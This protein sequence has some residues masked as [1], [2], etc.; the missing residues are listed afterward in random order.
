MGKQY[1]IYQETTQWSDS[2]A[3]NHIYIFLESIKGRRTAQAVAYI[4]AGDTQVRR[5]KTPCTLDLKE[6]T[7]EAVT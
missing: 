6:R 1:Y 7:F 2:N 5:L 3:A 4:R